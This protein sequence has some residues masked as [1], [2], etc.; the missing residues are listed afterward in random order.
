MYHEV[1]IYMLTYYVHIA[2]SELHVYTSHMNNINPYPFT[3]EDSVTTRRNFGEYLTQVAEHNKRFAITKR[4]QVV[5]LLVPLSDSRAIEQQAKQ[6]QLNTMY[7]ALDKMQGMI[8]DSTITDASKTV[9]EHLYAD[10]A[11]QEANA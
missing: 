11:E 7:K 2:S 8:S 6:E 3:Q 9:D 10:T 5:A 1:C 4:G